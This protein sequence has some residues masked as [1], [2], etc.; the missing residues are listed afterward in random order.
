VNQTPGL[1]TGLFTP[2]ATCEKMCARAFQFVQKAVI[3][4]AASPEMCVLSS[5]NWEN[6]ATL[7]LKE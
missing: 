3:Q 6:Y 7:R 4:R 2:D 5:T 1:S